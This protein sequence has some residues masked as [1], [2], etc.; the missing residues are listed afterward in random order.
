MAQLDIRLT[1]PDLWWVTQPDIWWVTQPYHKL[2]TAGYMG[3]GLGLG[4]L[5][6]KAQKRPLKVDI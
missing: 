5:N 4:G 3:L 6:L 2:V 1:Q